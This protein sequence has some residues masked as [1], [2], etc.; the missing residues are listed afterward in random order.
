[1]SVEFTAH[2]I[3][4]ND[5]VETKPQTA[6]LAAHP[7]HAEAQQRP[8]RSRDTKAMQLLN[9]SYGRFHYKFD[10]QRFNLSELAAQ[11]F[12]CHP[13]ELPQVH[14]GKQQYRTFDKLGTEVKT[15]YHN[16]FY[17]HLN[18]K[19]GSPTAE[20]A[21]FLSTYY[22]LLKALVEEHFKEELYVQRIPSFRIQL[23]GNRAIGQ[24][25]RDTDA[26]HRREETNVFLPL[27]PAYDSNAIWAESTI[28]K[29]DFS[30]LSANPGELIIWNGANLLHMNKINETGYSRVS[31]DFRVLPIKS[32][33][34]RPSLFS[35][36]TR[37]PMQLGHYFIE[38]K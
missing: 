36:S 21:E 17:G 10:V 25:H 35:L 11:M 4:L 34:E 26:G 3:R 1:M 12:D 15:I 31:V 27:T 9:L 5:G 29:R 30:C 23:P 14:R 6:L 8:T 13:S 33:Q 37:T 24:P 18:P 7:W 28:G 20:G 22:S 38:I 16:I 2:N 19:Q 32:Y